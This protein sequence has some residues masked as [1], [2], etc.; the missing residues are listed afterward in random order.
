M[1]TK[2]PIVIL[3]A[4]QSQRLGQAKQNL[5]Y[6]GQTLLQK[7]ITT[8]NLASD[9]V[10]VVLGAYSDTIMPSILFENANLLFNKHWAEGMASSIRLATTHLAQQEAILFMVCDQP[11]IE[12]EIL[13]EILS[14]F[15]SQNVDFVACKY[16]KNWGVPMLISKKY[17]PALLGL[18]GDTGAKVLVSKHL[19]HCTLI[20]F[21]KGNLDIDTLADYNML[22][23]QP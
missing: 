21:P 5:I 19:E 4:G 10:W 12:A 11:F 7:A 16:D 6:K 22:S 1:K 3:A 23:Q 9:N 14:V 15:S 2:I 13:N 17:Y 18:V 20:N 8:A